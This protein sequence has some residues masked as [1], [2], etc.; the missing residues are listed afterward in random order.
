[1]DGANI[2]SSLTKLTVLWGE[3]QLTV[4]SSGLPPGPCSA[5]VGNCRLDSFG[6]A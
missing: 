1:M 4:P 3:L 6:V 2:S 5:S